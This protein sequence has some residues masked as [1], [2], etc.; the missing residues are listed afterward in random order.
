[1][2]SLFL[3]WVPEFQNTMR[4]LKTPGPGPQVFLQGT[5]F[6]SESYATVEALPASLNKPTT[7]KRIAQVITKVN[8]DMT[9]LHSRMVYIYTHVY[10]T[11]KD[12]HAQHWWPVGTSNVFLMMGKILKILER[13]NPN[14]FKSC[15][16][17]RCGAYPFVKS[18]IA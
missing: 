3:V 17:C 12:L 18:L 7:C 16:I 9:E 10:M 13:Y 15:R 11:V 6:P 1:V 2:L 4:F 8:N 14:H 5:S